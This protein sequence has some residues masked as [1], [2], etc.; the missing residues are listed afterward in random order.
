MESLL[1]IISLIGSIYFGYNIKDCKSCSQYPI[2]KKPLEAKKINV[3]QC[4][5]EPNNRV[6]EF[7]TTT[8]IMPLDDFKEL[9]IECINRKSSVEMCE[10]E[11]DKYNKWRKRWK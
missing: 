3:R 11:I 7:N 9:T 10:K 4:T 5:E 8:V 2:I 6:C 1:L